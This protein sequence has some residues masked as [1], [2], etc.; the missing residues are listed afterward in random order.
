M[1]VIWVTKELLH[2][3]FFCSSSSNVPTNLVCILYNFRHNQLKQSTNLCSIRY[4]TW[5]LFSRFTLAFFGKWVL[6]LLCLLF[7]EC[8]VVK[9]ETVAK[10]KASRDGGSRE[11]IIN[12]QVVKNS[13]R[14][15][16]LQHRW[17]FTILQTIDK[18][19]VQFYGY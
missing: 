19:G 12:F 13:W 2:T 1:Y 3:Q 10:Q 4:V 15:N 6:L 17:F 7:L 16:G 8:Y 5:L 9:V 14:M 18:K 11:I